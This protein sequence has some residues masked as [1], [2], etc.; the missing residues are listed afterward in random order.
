MKLSHSMNGSNVWG[1]LAPY[2]YD[3]LWFKWNIYKTG[4]IFLSGLMI[5][6]T[7]SYAL[8]LCYYYIIIIYFLYYIIIILIIIIYIIYFLLYNTNLK[9]VFC[10]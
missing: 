1:S 8:S 2:G 6:G 3:L 9:S 5:I 4:S 10:G 7:F